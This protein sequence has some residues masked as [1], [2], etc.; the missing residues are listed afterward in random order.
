MR[1]GTI[2][3]PPVIRK[4]CRFGLPVIFFL[5]VI[6]IEFGFNDNAI[7]IPSYI[8]DQIVDL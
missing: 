2:K 6:P 3:M 8:N 1:F 5:S 4:F 7:F